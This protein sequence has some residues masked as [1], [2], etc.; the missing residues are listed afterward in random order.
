MAA[1]P[2]SQRP[3]WNA[4]AEHQRA[5]EKRPLRALFAEDPRRT[6]RFS[7]EAAGL[8][9]DDSN[10][11]TEETLWLLLELAESSVLGD[12]TTPCSGPRRST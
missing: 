3:A 6:E 8:Y 4:L 1:T 10:W 7:L 2:P 9:L 5:I 12:R 11:I